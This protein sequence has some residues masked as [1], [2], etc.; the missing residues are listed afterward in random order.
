MYSVQNDFCGFRRMIWGLYT[1]YATIY[2]MFK[3]KRFSRLL[4]LTKF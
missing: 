1:I 2:T 4:N 3:L